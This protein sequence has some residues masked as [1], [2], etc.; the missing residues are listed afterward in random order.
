MG[1]LHS[2]CLKARHFAARDADWKVITS[3]SHR[4]WTLNVELIA[5]VH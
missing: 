1:A 2:F 3:Q 5:V 4:R